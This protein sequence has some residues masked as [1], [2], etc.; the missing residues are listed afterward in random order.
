MAALG[1]GTLAILSG[2]VA[3]G[4]FLAF[5]AFA[6][7]PVMGRRVIEEDG[8][9]RIGSIAEAQVLSA[10]AAD[11]GRMFDREKGDIDK[12]IIKSGYV[13]QT[14]EEYY[15]RRI[16]GAIAYAILAGASG[17]ILDLGFIITA[18]LVTVGLLYGFTTPARKVQQTIRTRRERIQDE[19]GFGL[20][21]LVNL[22]NTGTSLS[23]AL[24]QMKDFGLFGKICD[25]VSSGLQTSKPIDNIV[26]D[27]LNS[28]PAPGQ[29][30]EFLALVKQSQVGGQ[31]QTGAMRTMAR[32]LRQRLA[33]RI[34]EKGGQA[35]VKATLVNTM[36]I[37]VASLIII[38]VPGLVLFM[39]IGFF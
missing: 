5:A 15:A 11:V 3:L 33:N 19:M 17:F 34:M 13:Y 21:Q 25:T 38:G 14:A 2:L 36:V 6:I 22:L 7:P 39:S 10:V 23:D 4:I 26:I 28:V 18:L 29:L 27:V 12:L 24:A 16:L 1:I 31:V 9:R 20:E 32:M 30:E 37:V 35:K 8:R